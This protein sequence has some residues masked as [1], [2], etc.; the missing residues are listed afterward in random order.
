MTVDP[1][2]VQWLDTP[3]PTEQA[4]RL[5]GSISGN[6]VEL[7]ARHLMRPELFLDV[8]TCA[9]C[10][11]AWFPDIDAHRFAYPEVAD[12]PDFEMLIRH[13]L[14]LASGLSWKVHVLE[15]LPR[16]GARSLLEVGC[17]AGVWLDYCRSMWD[18]DVVGVEPSAYGRWGGELL[19][20][21]ILAT[22]MSAASELAGRRFDI[23]C[24]IEVIEHVADPVGFLTEL[25]SFTAP[26]GMTVLTTPTSAALSRAT[27]PGELYAA[28]SA[29]S[30]Y[31]LASAEAL[32][33]LAR[34]AGFGWCGVEAV[35]YTHFV[36]LAD[37]PVPLGAAVDPSTRVAAYHRARAVRPA[38]PR[39][40]L[41]DLIGAYVWERE[42]G[43]EPDQT[44]EQ[45]IAVAL[46][47]QF[48]IELLD[49]APLVDRAITAR[50]TAQL[51]RA[52]PYSLVSYLYWRGQRDDLSERARTEMWE[53]GA[54]V[55]AHGLVVDPVNL[56][57]LRGP[58][59]LLV[60][61]LGGRPPGRLGATAREHVALLPDGG[62]VEIRDPRRRS[63]MVAAA[64]AVARRLPTSARR[65]VRRGISAL[66]PR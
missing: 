1:M 9:A 7:R 56:F 42:A 52:M 31:F 66:R 62:A 24:A 16:A 30:H 49:L 26:G 45:Q 38:D 37:E 58:L 17:G 51:G 10:T 21:P 33:D 28:L 64:A 50:S 39:T 59:D 15:R 6:T 54:A 44:L 46:D 63:P 5:C 57:M 65:L 12:D 2:L 47:E 34:D 14:E 55:A 3:T 20:V 8:A 61:A 29:G 19:D 40:C 32:A 23:V 4:C 18:V 25:R 11:S 53:A 27:P 22:E 43:A 41:G 36:V 48:D 13:Y 35:G 60:L